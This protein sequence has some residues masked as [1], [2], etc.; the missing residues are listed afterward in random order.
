[1]TIGIFLQGSPLRNEFN[2]IINHFTEHGLDLKLLE[3]IYRT[4][5]LLKEGERL[6]KRVNQIIS[7]QQ[8]G[9]VR[10]ILTH[11]ECLLK[12]KKRPLSYQYTRLLNKLLHYSLK[13]FMFIY[14]SIICVSDQ[15]RTR[16]SPRSVY[17]IYFWHIL[18][19]DCYD[20]WEKFI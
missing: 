10:L 14:L 6:P 16:T 9:N 13:F 5:Y 19:N 4:P 1:M 17:W 7:D 8:E 12:L 2:Q 20:Y 15:I 18:V 11:L 3:D